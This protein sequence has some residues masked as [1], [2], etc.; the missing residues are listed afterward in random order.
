[1]IHDKQASYFDI[2][3]PHMM[4]NIVKSPTIR[5]IIGVKTHLLIISLL[6]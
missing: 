1:M 5:R 6:K 2:F 3:E 4:N